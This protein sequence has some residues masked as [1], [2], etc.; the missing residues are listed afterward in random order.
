MGLLGMLENRE[1]DAG[2]EIEQHRHNPE[3]YEKKPQHAA[4]DGQAL[5]LVPMSRS[6]ENSLQHLRRLVRCHDID[7]HHLP[8]TTT[9]D[10]ADQ[11]AQWI[12][13]GV[14]HSPALLEEREL[15]P[16]VMP[17]EDAPR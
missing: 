17:R 16:S 3:P 1:A 4:Q 2:I 5:S 7:P 13:Q 12:V 8:E 6:S 11:L 10:L 9:V 15:R 14:A